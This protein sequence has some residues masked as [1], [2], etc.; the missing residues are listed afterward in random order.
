MARAEVPRI[1]RVLLPVRQ[2]DGSRRFYQALLGARGRPVG[3]GRVYF[4]CGGTILAL[5]D[6]STESAIS[7]LPEPLY[8]ATAEIDAVFAR[9]SRL[10]CLSS[11]LIHNDPA[12]PAGRV[13]VRPW[14]ERSFYAVDPSGHPLCFVDD[15]TLFTGVRV[16]GTAHRA[17]ARARS[18]SPAR[19]RSG[20]HA[21]RRRRASAGTPGRRSSGSYARPRVNAA[22]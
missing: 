17:R 4:D 13:I 15:A 9:A 10:G 19:D 11:E 2:L 5:V 14:G 1:F 16:R 7:P 8:F 20:R 3:G 6:A 21:P 22:R 12:N 18:P